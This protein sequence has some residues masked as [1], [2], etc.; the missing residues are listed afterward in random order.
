ML[1]SARNGKQI[2]FPGMA[3]PEAV[4]VKTFK[5]AKKAKDMSVY[6]G[7]VKYMHLLAKIFPHKLV[8]KTWMKQIKDYI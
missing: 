6:G 8:M 2:H 3:L 4:A 1:E 5:D 7:Y